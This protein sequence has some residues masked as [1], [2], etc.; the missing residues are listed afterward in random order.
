MDPFE[1]GDMNEGVDLSQVQPIENKLLQ[2]IETFRSN[3]QGYKQLL[4][5]TTVRDDEESAPVEMAPMYEY[6]WLYLQSIGYWYGLLANKEPVQPEFDDEELRAA[7]ENLTAQ[8][9]AIAENS[10]DGA[11]MLSWELY[12]QNT[13]HPFN[14]PSRTVGSD[15][16]DNEDS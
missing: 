5:D 9:K 8:L 15:A 4:Y 2:D 10:T 6:L 16:E 11:T 12:K 14:F 7:F 3:L 13:E 1:G